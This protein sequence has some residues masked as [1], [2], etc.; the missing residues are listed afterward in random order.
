MFRVVYSRDVTKLYDAWINVGSLYLDEE[1]KPTAIHISNQLA[2]VLEL[3]HPA[4]D[5]TVAAIE[6]ERNYERSESGSEGR[7]GNGGGLA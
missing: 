3:E 5:V 6:I 2:T 7:L 1:A 4:F